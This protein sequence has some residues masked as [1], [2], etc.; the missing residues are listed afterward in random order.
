MTSKRVR[1]P[2]AK[3]IQLRLEAGDA[4]ALVAL[5]QSYKKKQHG[6]KPMQRK[7]SHSRAKPFLAYDLET[8][9]I[10]EGTPTVKYLTAY[11]E[12]GDF[13]L[14]EIIKGKNRYAHLCDVLSRELLVERFNGYRFVA[15]NGN[16]FDV[17]FIARALLE[18]D[19]YVIKPYLTRSKS[20]RGLKIIGVGDKEGLEWEF[21]DGMAMTGLDSAKMKLEK[22]VGLMAPQYPKLTLDFSSEEFDPRNKKHVAYAERDAEAL[23][24]AMKRASEIVKELTGNDLQPT[25]GNLAIKY[26]QAQLPS[27][28]RIWKPSQELREVLHGPAKRGGFCWIQKQYV[29]PVWKYDINQAYAAAMR[30]AELP[31]GSCIKTAK[32]IDNKPGVYRATI[33]RDKRSPVPFYYRDAETNAGRFTNGKQADTWILS[34]E[35]MHLIDDGWN[36]AIDGGYY[37]QSSFNMRDMVDNLERLRFTDPGGPSGALGTMVKQIGNSAYGKTLEQLGGIELVMSRTHPDSDDP[38]RRYNLYMPDEPGLENIYFRLGDSFPKPYHQPQIGCFITAHPRLILRSAALKA[39]SHFI[40][41]DTDALAFSKPVDFLKVD[42]RHYGDWKLESD[43]VEYIFVA[44]KVYHG[45][46]AKHAKGLYVRE[47]EKSDFEKW[48]DGVPPTQMQT[49]RQNF[50]RFMAG[51]EMFIGQERSGT[52]VRKS[53]QVALVNG[54]FIPV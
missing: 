19:S 36:V 53:K 52:D 11:G 51:Q 46:D 25:M 27:H 1:F 40:Y 33:S 5:D 6:N 48:F 10:A 12:D 37:W 20:I 2:T 35:V 28:V 34:T 47:L 44:K 7:K 17:F 54:E 31:H 21:L 23:Y 41:A 16:G 39:P 13:K 38:G 18:S 15:W 29:G 50:V 3:E 30:D 24:Y 43:G 14:S 22:F 32:F 9:R 26:F 4:G 49:Q 8:T 42:P 45:E